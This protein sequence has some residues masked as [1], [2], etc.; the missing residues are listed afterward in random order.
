MGG[1]KI[2]GFI[3]TCIPF[4]LAIAVFALILSLRIAHVFRPAVIQVRYGFTIPIP[5]IF[6]ILLLILSKDRWIN[7]SIFLLFT[8]AIFAMAL[9]GVWASGQTEGQLISGILPDSDAAFYYFD[10][11]RYINGFQFSFF[12]ARRIFFPAFLGILLALSNGNLQIT[13]GIITFLLAISC[14]YTTSAVWKRFGSIPASLFFILI[15]SFARLSIGELMSESLGLIL[16]CFGLYFTLLFLDQEKTSYLYLASFSLVLGLITRAGPIG[17]FPFLMLGI[18]FAKKSRFSFK[19]I[20]LPF[21]ISIFTV[22]LSFLGI[23]HYLSP[24]GSI[25][26]ANFAHS[27]YGIANGGTG[28]TAIYLDHPEIGII[29]EPNFTKTIYKYAFD[30]IK[31]NPQNLLK[32]IVVQY[33]QIFNFPDRKGFFCF[34]GGEN[35]L[36]YIVAQIL[37][38]ALCFYGIYAVF[39]KKNF[40]ENKCFL[41][42]LL[43][44]LLTVPLFPFSDFK[45]MRVYAAAIP[46]IAIF[47][48]IG[49]AVLLDKK[50]FTKVNC[51]PLA[52][53]KKALIPGFF[54]VILFL[55]IMVLPLFIRIENSAKTLQTDQVCHQPES[56]ELIVKVNK[57]SYL[58]LL[59]ES[60][61]YLDWLPYF[62]ESRFKTY[63]HN[64]PYAT[65]D[66]FTNVSAPAYITS[67]IDLQNG[68]SAI[69]I[70]QNEKNLLSDATLL[71]CGTWDNYNFSTKN[72]N[73]FF[74]NEVFE[75]D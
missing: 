66:A 23:S 3:K 38:F 12:G 33:P 74:V 26:F 31:T 46:F 75:I 36:V 44:I 25:P 27:L 32:G 16:G 72:A 40:K 4:L 47:P 10:A 73:L 51:F 2:K 52:K 24:E 19:K 6:I 28:W 21:C 22:L 29:P 7:H 37:I 20:F 35:Q 71:L 65:V 67:T 34:F 49:L 58:G 62:H 14:F 13:L 41:Y 17:L 48:T 60:D 30:S 45:E 1:L 70:F 53:D 54:A 50:I 18:F 15:F 39:K 61:F 9:A 68:Q 63:L 64:L 43:G 56:Q 8:S 42:G 5:A 59:K 57:G 55:C 11:L 69:L